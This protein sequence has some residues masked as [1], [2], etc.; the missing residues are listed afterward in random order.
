VPGNSAPPPPGSSIPSFMG[1][2][3]SS[4][5]TKSGNTISGDGP[6]IVVVQTDAGYQPDPGHPGTGTVV[7]TFCP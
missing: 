7:A 2:V 3:V 1:V 5:I 4:Q 6:R